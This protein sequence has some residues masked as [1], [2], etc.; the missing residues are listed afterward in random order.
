MTTRGKSKNAPARDGLSLQAVAAINELYRRTDELYH[1]VARGMGLADCA[2]EILYSLM[3]QDGLTQ[4]QLC[5]TSFSTKQT[6][7]SSLKRLGEQGLVET[8]GDK[9]RTVHLTK[10]GS[11]FV[12]EKVAPVLAAECAAVEVFSPS[13]QEHLIEAARRYTDVLAAGFEGLKA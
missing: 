7:N 1:E 13:Q 11:V 5:R 3:E 9:G 2:F 10:A 4:A 6:V 12:R 8:R